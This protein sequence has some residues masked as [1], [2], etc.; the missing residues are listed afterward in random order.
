MKIF[1]DLCG[2]PTPLNSDK[3]T[4]DPEQVFAGKPA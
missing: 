3:M 4:Q 2:G 1:G